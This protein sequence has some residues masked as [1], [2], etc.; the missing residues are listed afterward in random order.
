M[1]DPN[2]SPTITPAPR[3]LSRVLL[4]ETTTDNDGVREVETREATEEEMVELGWVR[5]ADIQAS[6]NGKTLRGAEAAGALALGEPIPD[7]DTNG[8]ANKTTIGTADVPARE[9]GSGPLR[10]KT[11]PDAQRNSDLDSADADHPVGNGHAPI[12]KMASGESVYA[13]EPKAG[14]LPSERIHEIA[15]VKPRERKPDGELWPVSI[16]MADVLEFLDERL[17]PK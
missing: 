16:T 17:G 12:G 1:T 6:V 4:I 11:L 2:G 7:L 10:A 5:V 9:D 15:S 8:H 3:I 14:K 13:E